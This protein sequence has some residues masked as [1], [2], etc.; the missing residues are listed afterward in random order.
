MA[1]LRFARAEYTGDYVS[2]KNALINI[3][4]SLS[5]TLNEINLSADQVFSGSAQVSDSAQTFSEELRIRPVLLRNLR[6]P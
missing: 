2:I 3:R 4:E 5:N 6:L 1:T